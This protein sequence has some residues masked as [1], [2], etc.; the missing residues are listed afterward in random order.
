M[1]LVSFILFLSGLGDV[2]KN[3]SFL[4]WSLVIF[5]MSD[6]AAVLYSLT[7]RSLSVEILSIMLSDNWINNLSLSV[8]KTSPFNGRTLSVKVVHKD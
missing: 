7:K 6:L 2:C 1:L 3:D 8:A 5:S 4:K